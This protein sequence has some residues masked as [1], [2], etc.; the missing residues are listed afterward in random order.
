MI[1]NKLEDVYVSFQDT[2]TVLATSVAGS[3]A[4]IV[5]CAVLGRRMLRVRDLD[6]ASIGPTSSGTAICGYFFVLIGLV[7]LALP[8]PVVEEMQSSVDFDVV[9]VVRAIISVAT[10]TLTV[11]T[12]H[13]M[14]YRNTVTYWIVLK[15]LQGGLASFVTISAAYNLYS[16]PMC[17]IVASIGA[18]CFFFTSE[19]LFSTTVDDNCNIIS[20]H[21]ICGILSCLLPPFFGSKA[22]I[23]FPATF[24]FYLNVIHLAWQVV[25]C[26]AAVILVGVIF[27]LVFFILSFLYLLRNNNE[28]LAHD[29]ANRVKKEKEKIA[30]SEP[31]VEMDYILPSVDHKE[32]E[33]AEMKT[34]TK[35]KVLGDGDYET[36]KQNIVVNAQNVNKTP[37][38]FTETNKFSNAKFK[39]ALK[40]C[41][42]IKKRSGVITKTKRQTQPQKRDNVDA[43]NPFH[44]DDSLQD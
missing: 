37:F 24:K 42:S 1:E 29:R 13:L 23:G 33:C 8:S 44:D 11:F 31:V 16:V 27:S 9:L 10:G 4:A 5:G 6:A 2:A 36:Q 30:A 7:A 21:F 22:N 34:F 20:V 32:L 28:K 3:T 17:A 35:L 41:K 25:C 12:L 18:V 19:F 40:A 43:K 15:F 39:R 14:F 38:D 26:F